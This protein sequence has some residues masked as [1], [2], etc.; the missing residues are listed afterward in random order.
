[1]ETASA[2]VD[3][4]SSIVSNGGSSTAVNGAISSTVNN[5]ATAN[6]STTDAD[7]VS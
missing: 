3:G 2:N 4:S 7:I 6:L 1:M 5:I